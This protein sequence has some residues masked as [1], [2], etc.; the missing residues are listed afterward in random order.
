VCDLG[1]LRPSKT[2]T[3][4]IVVRTVEAGSYTNRAFVSFGGGAS[5]LELDGF[6]NQD[7]ARARVEA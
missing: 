6:D 3:V 5:A 7:T 2:V 4:W 1:T